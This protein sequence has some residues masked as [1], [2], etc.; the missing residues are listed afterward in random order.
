MTDFEV[1]GDSRR[2]RHR[3]AKCHDREM[4]CGDARM[5]RPEINR[6]SARTPRVL[7]H[8]QRDG[9]GWSSTGPAHIPPRAN[10]N[11]WPG[12]PTS[13]FFGIEDTIT[14]PEIF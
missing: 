4:K 5:P 1:D 2:L 9:G 11:F 8:L 6:P 7:F 14:S 13:R 3:P 12:P 10:S